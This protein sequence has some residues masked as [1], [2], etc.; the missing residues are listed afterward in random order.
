MG[1]AFSYMIC[2]ILHGERLVRMV[3]DIPDTFENIRGRI[4]RNLCL[5]VRCMGTGTNASNILS[6]LNRC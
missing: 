6:T 3:L 2:H 1:S 5:R 4:K